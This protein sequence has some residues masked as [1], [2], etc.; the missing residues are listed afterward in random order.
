M[1]ISR[2]LSLGVD[3]GVQIDLAHGLDNGDP[4]RTEVALQNISLECVTRSLAA[5][6]ITSYM[7]LL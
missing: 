6:F 1:Q 7:H 5:V 2:T 3:T 4:A